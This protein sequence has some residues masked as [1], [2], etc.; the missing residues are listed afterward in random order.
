MKKSMLVAVA[1][2]G[3]VALVGSGVWVGRAMAT[4]AP[5]QTPLTYAGTLTD[6]DGKPYPTAQDVQLKFWDAAVA[7]NLKCTVPTVQAE[8][9]TGRFAVV[10]GGDC[11]Q[12]VR[13]TADLWSEAAV[14][15]AKTVMPRVHVGAVPFA[16]EAD[17]AKV[18]GV[19]AAASGALK[20]QVDGLQKTLDG[21]GG[22]GKVGGGPSIVDV[23]GQSIGTL[24]S[25]ETSGVLHILTKTGDL[26]VTDA[27]GG[28]PNPQNAMNIWYSEANCKGEMLISIGGFSAYLA[29]IV[30]PYEDLYGSG[31][32]IPSTPKGSP[33]VPSQKFF[34]KSSFYSGNCV[35]VNPQNS[36][37]VSGGLAVKPVQGAVVGIPG[38]ISGPLSLAP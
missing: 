21:L 12:A 11:V 20:T 13:D 22:G 29:A 37:Y 14:G 36:G 32:L 35:P 6:K 19:A 23:T 34:Y 25:A 2:M 24:L 4:G 33:I 38:K 9:G 31:Y 26:L 16:L 30:I 17:S 18:A 7:G 28:W 15:A 10:L 8:A 3:A 27:M 5:V 1:A